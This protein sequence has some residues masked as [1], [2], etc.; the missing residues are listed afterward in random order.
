MINEYMEKWV[1]EFDLPP[2]IAEDRGGVYTIPMDEE[3]M[4]E[5]KDLPPGISI[6]CKIAQAP[7]KGK[8]EFFVH[9]L[10][11]NL[12]GQGTDG[13][14]L[15]LTEE[16]NY[17]TLSYDMEYSLEYNEFKDIIEDVFNVV[18]FWREEARLHKS[19]KLF[20]T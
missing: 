3:T 12:L 6:F 7:E 5:I 19:G 20:P 10:H 13:A 18:D 2:T 11:G 8:E 16:G 17:L 9:M 1:K 14:A 4:I 15:G